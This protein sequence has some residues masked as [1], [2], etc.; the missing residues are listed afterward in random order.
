MKQNTIFLALISLPVEEGEKNKMSI[1][2]ILLEGKKIMGI[3]Q[4]RATHWAALGRGL[5]VRIRCNYKLAVG[6]GA[7][8]PGGD[9]EEGA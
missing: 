5:E 4:S 2:H 1:F 6:V 9:T 7:E 3:N 8:L